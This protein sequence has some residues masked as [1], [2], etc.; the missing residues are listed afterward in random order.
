MEHVN[1]CQP[2]FHCDVLHFSIIK[3][4]IEWTTC[5]DL[6]IMW[7]YFE[8]KSLGSHYVSGDSGMPAT[9][10]YNQMPEL[11]PTGTYSSSDR[12]SSTSG[13][14]RTTQEK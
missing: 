6:T 3:N 10:P 11:H 8:Y 14:K 5:L 9:I 1:V 12:G 2:Y 13:K 4:R 7:W